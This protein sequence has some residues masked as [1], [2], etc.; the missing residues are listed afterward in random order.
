M[1]NALAQVNSDCREALKNLNNKLETMGGVLDEGEDDLDRMMNGKLT[2]DEYA[3]AS[4]VKLQDDDGK[5]DREFTAEMMGKLDE[6][7]WH[8]LND[9]L[10]GV[11]PRGK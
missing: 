11:E 7:L 2:A 4:A 8:L 3:K 5:G 9:K 1:L 6:Y 10:E